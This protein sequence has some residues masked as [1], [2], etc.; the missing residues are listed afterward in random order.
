[1]RN[2]W[3]TLMMLGHFENR[4]RSHTIASFDFYMQTSW[5]INA[6][7]KTVSVMA[8]DGLAWLW[9]IGVALWHLRITWDTQRM[10]F[11]TNSFHVL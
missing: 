10:Y 11:A 6:T 9:C 5:M 1:M 8:V 3:C 7:P 4:P 2:S